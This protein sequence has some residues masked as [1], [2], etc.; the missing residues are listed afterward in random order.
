[1][2]IEYEEEEDTRGA[3]PTMQEQLIS[4]WNDEEFEDLTLTTESDLK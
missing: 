2:E 4:M 1:M 3:C